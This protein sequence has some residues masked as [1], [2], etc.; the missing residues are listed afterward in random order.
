MGYKPQINLFK[1]N[2]KTENMKKLFFV[3]AIAVLAASCNG[4]KDADSTT[5]T[6]STE[7]SATTT[8]SATT[9]QS[10]TTTTTVTTTDGAATTA[11]PSK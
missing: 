9:E 6:A 7:Q 11:T 4:G 8:P 5:T 1:Q 2:Q 10:A 3:F